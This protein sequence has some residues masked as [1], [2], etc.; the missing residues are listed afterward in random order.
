[1]RSNLVY[2]IKPRGHSRT[3]T[4]QQILNQENEPV[5]R[6]PGVSAD[7]QAP[8]P[9]GK[10]YQQTGYRNLNVYRLM[11]SK[12]KAKNAH[13]ITLKSSYFIR[14]TGVAVTT[15]KAGKKARKSTQKPPTPQEVRRKFV[16]KATKHDIPSRSKSRKRAGQRHDPDSE[17]ES[18]QD[19]DNLPFIS[20]KRAAQQR[21]A[22]DPKHYQKEQRSGEQ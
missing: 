3:L 18:E 16:K 10:L 5:V 12:V 1:M 11:E 8:V 14:K 4:E 2:D 19:S 6:K 21:L 22:A 7:N 13:A 15:R 9:S 20:A 17:S